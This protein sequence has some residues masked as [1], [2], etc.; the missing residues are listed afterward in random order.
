MVRLAPLFENGFLQ[1]PRY[2]PFWARDMRLLSAFFA[3]SAFAGRIKL[4][5]IDLDRFIALEEEGQ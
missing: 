2:V 4:D 3:F 1:P 5:L